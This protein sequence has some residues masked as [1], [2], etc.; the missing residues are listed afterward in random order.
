[1]FTLRDEVIDKLFGDPV[2]AL[3]AI[4]GIELDYFQ[5]AR[6]RL[7]WFVPHKIDSSGWGTGKTLEEW[8]Y[9]ILR[10]VLL[11]NNDIGVYYPIFQT[12]KDEWWK[13]FSEIRHPVLESQFRPR[14]HEWKDAGCWRCE[15]KNGSIISLPAPG[16]LSNAM[17][18]ASRTFNTMIIGEYTQAAMKGEGVDELIGRVRGPNFNKQHPIWSNHS[19]LSAHAE[20]PTH[21]SYRYFKAVRDAVLGKFTEKE[22]H[23][24]ATFT[25]CFQDWSEKPIGMRIADRGLRNGATTNAQTFRSRYREDATIAK[26]KR[27]LAK[28][29]FRRR[30]L[31]I[32]SQDGKGWY[33]ADMI[34]GVLRSALKPQAGR[35]LADEIFV[36]GKDTAPGE[37]GK[38]D[39]CAF[40]VWRIVEILGDQGSGLRVQGS[41]QEFTTEINGRYFHISPVFA[42]MLKNVDAGQISGFVHYLHRVFGFAKIVLDPRG[43]GSWVYKELIKSK[44]LIFN[45]ITDC[46]PL[47]K[48]DE[49]NWEDKQ[50][51]V[52]YFDRGTELDVLWQPRFLQSDDGLLEAAHRT[53]REGFEAK[54]FL[55]P[56]LREN[57]D[58]AEF[59]T[60]SDAEKWASI[61]LDIAWKQ[62]PAI[63]VKVDPEGKPILSKRGF[64]NF[65]AMGSKKKDAIYAAMY[66]YVA[67]KLIL[68]SILSGADVYEDS[69]AVG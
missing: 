19:L 39:W 42:H 33:P 68:H 67:A 10:A 49:P 53:F 26:S 1:M 30:L 27:S 12:G 3:F 16:F 24:N 31:G 59:E 5:A 14:K 40:V 41:G 44:Q 29:E 11:P 64:Y 35:L 34:K 28:D 52:V 46:V 60:F 2:M 18:Q 61:Y 55:W 48:L 22:Q 58:R 50:P 4:T 17:N 51:I 69:V 15:F 43:G 47:C 65:E 63:R 13:Y 57:R 45:A 32:W 8:G 37:S 20:S 54:E 9:A 25:A 62:A 21:P 6:L 66:G 36:L 56:Q 38:A 7:Y 23:T